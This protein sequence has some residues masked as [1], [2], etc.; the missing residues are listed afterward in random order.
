MNNKVTRAARRAA[1]VRV[2]HSRVVFRGILS[3]HGLHSTV[4]LRGLGSFGHESGALALEFRHSPSS[5]TKG[6]LT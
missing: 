4:Q 6:S 2:T 1:D 5:R 3:E